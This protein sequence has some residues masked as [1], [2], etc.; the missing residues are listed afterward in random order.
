VLPQRDASAL[1]RAISETYHRPKFRGFSPI[2]AEPFV[3][4]ILH[5]TELKWPGVGNMTGG[6]DLRIRTLRAAYRRGRLDPRSVLS[7]TLERIRAGGINPV[8]IHLLSEQEVSTQLDWLPVL[9]N[10]SLP[11]WGIPFAI[12][13][14]MD[15]KGA[16]TTAGCPGFSYIPDASAPVL[17]KLLAAGAILVGKTSMD[18]FATGTTGTRSPYGPSP[19]ALNPDYVAGGSSSGS[20]VAVASGLVSFSLG[21]DTAG[22]GRIPAAFNSIVGLKPTRGRVSIRGIVPAC[23]SIDCVSVFANDVEDATEVLKVIEGYDPQE[24]YSRPIESPSR[25]ASAGCGLRLGVPRRDQ[26]EFFGCTRSAVAFDRTLDRLRMLGADLVE[27]DFTPFAEVAEM[28]Y[29]GPWMAE[30]YSSLRE[31]FETHPDK[32]HPVTYR[33]IAGSTQFSAA[34]AFAAAHRLNDLKR[35]IQPVWDKF[36]V[37]VTPTVPRAYTIDEVLADPVRLNNNLGYYTN[38]VNLL[39]LCAIAVPAEVDTDRLPF[40]ITLAAP[41]WT[42]DAICAIAA[43]FYSMAANRTGMST[44]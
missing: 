33:A 42:E 9:A 22:S 40:G 32:I 27:F 1:N 10:D 38:F 7:A 31:F 26:R 28:I 39:D 4:P 17:D 36:D 12:K 37:M 21:T 13:D 44:L 43:D 6:T 20:A 29:R 41:A 18:Q 30:R 35:I 15:L 14:N 8:W 11:L 25:P 3:A 16:P 5:T 2:Y 24:S 34:D 19:S 23:R